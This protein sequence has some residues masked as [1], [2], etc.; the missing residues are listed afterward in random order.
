MIKEVLRFCR[1]QKQPGL[2]F[3]SGKREFNFNEIGGL[4][5]AGW[6]EATY[7]KEKQADERSFEEQCNEVLDVLVAHENSWPFRK[8]VDREKVRDFYDVIKQP[9]DLESV[10]KKVERTVRVRSGEK[11]LPTE[12]EEMKEASVDGKVDMRPY[13]GMEDFK[14]DIK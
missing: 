10:Q 12:L 2:D 3:S 6:D 7:L 14:A 4:V 5:E 11:L 1:F 9:M 13:G 8:A